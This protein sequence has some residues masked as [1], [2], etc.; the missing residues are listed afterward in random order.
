MCARPDVVREAARSDHP[1][2]APG[3]HPL[4]ERRRT[5]G[6]RSL[7]HAGK[8][9]RVVNPPAVE[10]DTLE[11]RPVQEPEVALAADGG[12][13]L[14]LVRARD[15]AGREGRVVHEDDARPLVHRGAQC[16]EVETPLPVLHVEGDERRDGARQPDAVDHPRVRRVR[17]DDLV[18]RVRQ[19]EQGVEHRVALAARDHDLAGAGRSAA[20]RDARRRR[21]P[22]PS[23]RRGP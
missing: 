23:G 14:E 1:A 20:P 13:R 9:R 5:D 4:L 19:A 12:D 18:A 6:H 8:R 16:V 7:P 10:E 11:S 22:P 21:T 2:D 3:D 17:E 15:P